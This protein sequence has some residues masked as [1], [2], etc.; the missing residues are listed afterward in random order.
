MFG[1][2]GEKLPIFVKK[3]Q[4]PRLNEILLCEWSYF[5][6]YF[7]GVCSFFWFDKLNSD[8][9][10]TLQYDVVPVIVSSRMF[11]SSTAI[12]R[13]LR[14]TTLSTMPLSLFAG[15]CV[16]EVLLTAT[17]FIAQKT[18]ILLQLSLEWVIKNRTQV[19]FFFLISR[20]CHL[21]TLCYHGWQITRQRSHSNFLISWKIKITLKFRAEIKSNSPSM[22]Q[23][24]LRRKIYET[25]TGTCWSNSYTRK[26]S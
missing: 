17:H 10:D 18:F 13:P 6:C 22:F 4:Q 7:S 20:A 14:N 19:K 26:S 9:P 5:L 3:S 12:P 1:F 23:I 16:L 11:L 25:Y 8:D 21:I 24:P 2:K 15:L